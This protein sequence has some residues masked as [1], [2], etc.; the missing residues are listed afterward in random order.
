MRSFPEA[1]GRGLDIRQGVQVEKLCFRDEVFFAETVDTSSKDMPTS[2]GFSGP[3]DAVLL[4]APGPQTADLI[5]G[6]LP[7][8]SDLLQAARK[9][10]YT[11]QFSVLV[12]Y[13]FMRDA[14]S[15]IHNPTSKIAKIVN[16]AK[17]P[18][19]P[20]KSAFVVFCSPEWSLE[21]LDKSKDEVAEIILKDLENILSEHG[22]AVDDW[23]KPAY[24][25]AHSWR[26]CRLE[27]PAGLSPETQIDATSTLAVAGDWIML[28]DTHG[29]LSSGINAARQIE[30]K[31]SNRS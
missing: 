18:D 14:P 29:A 12:G 21:N 22:V 19:R 10:T 31:L 28:P 20:E 27:N 16:Q 23:G 1:L 4:T 11:P 3:F 8:G 25:A 17:K 9:V 13:D 30:T 26:Y 15:I 2:D 6:L 7:I 5:E 24:L